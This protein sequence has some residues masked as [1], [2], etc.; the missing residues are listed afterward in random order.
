MKFKTEIT[1]RNWNNGWVDAS[2]RLP[3]KDS[4]CYI[5]YFVRTIEYDSKTMKSKSVIKDNW[6]GY[7]DF[8]NDKWDY[9]SLC[10]SI[11]N[12]HYSDS[13][14]D[15]IIMPLNEKFKKNDYVISGHNFEIIDSDVFET[16]SNR[17]YVLCRDNDFGGCGHVRV[18][19]M[20]IEILAWC[21]VPDEPINPFE[22]QE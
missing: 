4:E 1:T 13:F 16:D 22:K 12:P 5:L 19:S 15:S 10:D 7:C 20:E 3:N 18:Q 9:S 17:I 21:S 6:M 11:E 8:K 14:T 2:V